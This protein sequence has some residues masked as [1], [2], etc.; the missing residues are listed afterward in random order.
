MP[1]GFQ[2]R[3]CCFSKYEMIYHADLNENLL[4]RYK[5][6]E[7]KMLDLNGPIDSIQ[8]DL[9]KKLHY[10]KLRSQNVKT[11]FVNNKWL[12]LL[13]SASDTN[14]NENL[15][16]YFVIIVYQAFSNVK[17]YDYPHEDFCY[18]KS[19]PHQWSVVHML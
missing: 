5:F 14:V 3:F 18:F 13:N 7:M 11:H 9:F 2:Q 10:L 15:N 4:N 6:W 12:D 16:E 19:F 1:I 17:F 8:I